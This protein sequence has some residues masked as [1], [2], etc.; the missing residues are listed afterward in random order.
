M[1]LQPEPLLY[2][3][4]PLSCPYVPLTKELLLRK[5]RFVYGSTVLIS[6]ASLVADSQLIKDKVINERLLKFFKLCRSRASW[7]WWC[8]FRYAVYSAMCIT[9][10]KDAYLQRYMWIDLLNGYRDF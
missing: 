9:Q 5:K 3:N 2:S 7:W 6:E 8:Y 4:I 10:S 1:P